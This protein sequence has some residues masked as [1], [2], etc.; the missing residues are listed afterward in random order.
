MPEELAT[1]LSAQELRDLIEFLGVAGGFKV[2]RDEKNWFELRNDVAEILLNAGGGV[3][4]GTPE[5]DQ[6]GKRNYGRGV[7]IGL[8][9]KDLVAARAAAQKYKGWVD[10]EIKPQPWGQSDFRV[11]TTD[12]FYIRVTE[13]SK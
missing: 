5:A 8:V 6:P 4:G 12:G 11:S 2:I 13:P 10:S 3:P 9:S 7:E 1:Y